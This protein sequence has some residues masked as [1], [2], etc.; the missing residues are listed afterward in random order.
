MKSTQ[1]QKRNDSN[2]HCTMPQSKS[3]SPDDI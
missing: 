3:R 1:K 2:A